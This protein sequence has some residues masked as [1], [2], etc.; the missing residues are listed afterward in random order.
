MK[1]KI[2]SVVLVIALVASIAIPAFAVSATGPHNGNNYDL[3]LTLSSTRALATF[4]YSD[5]EASLRCSVTGE[6]WYA[7]QGRYVSCEP[8]VATG[9]SQ[10]AAIGTNLAYVNGVAIQNTLHS[11]TTTARADGSLVKTLSALY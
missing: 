1:R 11:A 8:G 3:T 2:V 5:S 7:A 6:I 4:G 10:V 9:L